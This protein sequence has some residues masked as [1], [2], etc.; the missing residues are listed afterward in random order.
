MK[1]KFGPLDVDYRVR[2]VAVCPEIQIGDY[3][4]PKHQ[5][6]FYG[7]DAKT[8]T[9]IQSVV[10]DVTENYRGLGTKGRSAGNPIELEQRVQKHFF[11]KRVFFDGETIQGRGHASGVGT[12]DGEGSALSTYEIKAREGSAGSNDQGAVE[13]GAKDQAEGQG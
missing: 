4:M 8:L 7:L 11:N 13:T 10:Y 12:R 5:K 6:I 2:A 9:G 1:K 3:H